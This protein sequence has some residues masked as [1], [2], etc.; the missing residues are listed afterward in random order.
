MQHCEI[1]C[2]APSRPSCLASNFPWLPRGYVIPSRLKSFS[3]AALATAINIASLEH[4]TI[5]KAVTGLKEAPSPP[6]LTQK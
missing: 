6:D 4:D 3:I 2:A 1:S 5:I